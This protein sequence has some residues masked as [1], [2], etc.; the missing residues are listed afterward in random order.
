VGPAHSAGQGMETGVMSSCSLLMAN[1]FGAFPFLINARGGY[2]GPEFQSAMKRILAQVNVEIVMRSDQGLRRAAP[3]DGSWNAPSLGSAAVDDWSRTVN[4]STARRSPSCDS[5]PDASCCETMQSRMMFSDRLLR[6]V[7]VLVC[8]TPE[9]ARHLGA[10]V[11]DVIE[12]AS[13]NLTRD[14]SITV[15]LEV[16]KVTFE[17]VHEQR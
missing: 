12:E 5:P 9:G 17:T 1:L 8:M 2:Q 14:V 7:F 15:R 10:H 6:L 13:G 3:S 11:D 4:A 16:G